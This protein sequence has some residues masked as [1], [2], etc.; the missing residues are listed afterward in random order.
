MIETPESPSRGVAWVVVQFIL[1]AALL[2]AGP[3]WHAQWDGRLG[4]PVGIALLLMSAWLGL[5]GKR[6]LGKQRSPFPRPKPHAELVTSGLYAHVR[7]PLYVAVIL[8]GFAWALL[9]QSW[10]A[11]VLALLQAP[12]FDAKARR[13]ERWLRKRF[14]EYADYA[15]RV[16]RFVP[17]LY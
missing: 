3:I 2:S 9:W 1:M 14:P 17:R 4:I 7:H 6:D 11:L 13:E 10:P 12:F 15:W 5:R 16:K 8:L